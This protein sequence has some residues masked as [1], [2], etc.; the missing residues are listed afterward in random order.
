[1]NLLQELVNQPVAQRFGWTLLHFVWQGALWAAF[2]AAL[3]AA[4]RDRSA[5]ARYLAGCLTLLL[6]AA[7]P[8]ATY[9]MLSARAGGELTFATAS[10]PAPPESIM[11][12]AEAS[13][14]MQLGPAH[15]LARLNQVLDA[16]VPWLAAGWG[17]GVML[18]TGR[19]VVGWLRLYHAHVWQ[20]QSLE[21]RLGERLRALQQ[22]L[23]VARP[24]RVMQSALVQVPTLLGWFRPVI[25][26]PASALTGLSPMQLELILA[27]ELAHLRRRDHWVNLGQVVLETLLF[28]HPAV[29][30]VSRC[31]REEREHCCDEMAVAAC[32]DRLAY[33]RA[34]MTLEELRG[35]PADLALAAGGG[36]L[37]ARI[38]RI[39]G[40][41]EPAHRGNLRAATGAALVLL[42]LTMFAVGAVLYATAERQFTAVT[43]FAVPLPQ[44]FVLHP[45]T[46]E[47]DLRRELESHAI[48]IKTP[49]MLNQVARDLERAAGESGVA[50]VLPVTPEVVRQWHRRVHVRV[51][52]GTR[53]LEIRVHAP[54]PDLAREMGTRLAM[55]YQQF[56]Q[57]IRTERLFKGLQE[58]EQELT[59][60]SNRVAALREQVNQRFV[61]QLG[62]PWGWESQPSFGGGRQDKP[63]PDTVVSQLTQA[64]EKLLSLQQQRAALERL[65][66]E[67]RPQVFLQFFPEEEILRRLLLD[68]KTSEQ[69]LAKL[70]VDYGSTHPSVRQAEAVQ[71]EIQRQIQERVAGI[72]S[73]LENMEHSMA[74]TCLLLEEQAKELRQQRALAAGNNQELTRLKADL[75]QAERVLEA[76]FLRYQQERIDT[77]LTERAD[78]HLTG[79]WLLMAP[80]SSTGPWRS[81][82]PW[83]VSLMGAGLL[84]SLA[85]MALRRSGGQTQL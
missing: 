64:R 17:L 59:H 29:W 51:I 8:V 85:G 34:L 56:L 75:Q 5:N 38:R 14:L 60:Q 16:G 65:P 45:A 80:E 46:S 36:S 21:A 18:L 78:P 35:A 1:M 84:T 73:G 67:R 23:R 57:Q 71:A 26:L 42:G 49:K 76:I 4:C 44:E 48:L 69:E 63:T 22:R 54:Q 6:M 3:R 83:D 47:L 30:W 15:Q 2:Y 58:L 41:P 61:E 13:P 70:R 52:P 9:R 77:R 39:L 68:L 24:V 62:E 31:V 81:S 66:L 82:Y 20:G 12:S 53:L 32:G 43:H 10:A 28:Y 7:T 74:Q 40:S 79:F 37:L 33:A 19:L 27:H 11:A 25:L 50:G 55:A 72:M